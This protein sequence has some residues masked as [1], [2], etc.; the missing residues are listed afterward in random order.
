[1]IITANIG[2]LPLSL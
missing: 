2:T 1:M